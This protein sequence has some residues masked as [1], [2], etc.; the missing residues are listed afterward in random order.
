M[1]NDANPKPR[2][3]ILSIEQLNMVD[4]AKLQ[5][6]ERSYILDYN[7]AFVTIYR[8]G[9]ATLR[10][11][12]LGGKEG[13]LFHDLDAMNEMIAS[14]SYPVKGNGGFWENEK[15]RVLK[16]NQSMP[17]YLSWLSEML[18]FNVEFSSDRSY[19][20]ELSAVATKVLGSKKKNKDLLRAYLTIYI[21]ELLRQKVKGEWKLQPQ[22]ALN[23]YYVPEIVKGNK[24]CTHWNYVGKRL[25]VSNAIPVDIEKL[26]DSS[27]EFY[28]AFGRKYVTPE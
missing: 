1:S 22:K 26:V 20:A 2:Y 9:S 7:G 14:R 25:K 28:P 6:I 17:Y 5:E 8:D 11:A 12:V 15:A 27:N 23:V 19:L 16:F 21:G 13:L 4:T 3:E 18:E 10:P 24:F